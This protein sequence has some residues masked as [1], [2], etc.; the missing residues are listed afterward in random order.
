MH[1]V[2]LCW[3]KKTT[4]MVFVKLISSLEGVL[5]GGMNSSGLGLSIGKLLSGLLMI[6]C[7]MWNFSGSSP[8]TR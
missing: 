1:K 5:V 7:S 8:I 6:L 4:R 2:S 3:P